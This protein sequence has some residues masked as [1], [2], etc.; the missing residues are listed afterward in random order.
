MNITATNMDV[1]LTP[2]L[3]PYA[4]DDGARAVWL[5]GHIILWGTVD[6]HRELVRAYAAIVDELTAEGHAE[7]DAA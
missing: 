4:S 3:N 1:A 6:E 5:G 7:G 2:R